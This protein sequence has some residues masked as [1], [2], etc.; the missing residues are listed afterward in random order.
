MR[1]LRLR[2]VEAT[3]KDRGVRVEVAES[4]VEG[5]LDCADPAALIPAE[6]VPGPVLLV[7]AGADTVWPSA[8]MAW[9]LSARLHRNDYPHGHVLLEYAGTGHALGYL[10]P[11]LP[12]GLLPPGVPDDAATRKARRDAWPQV[13]DFLRQ[14]SS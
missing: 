10:I 3:A 4:F 2:F 6:Q 9:A 14:G 8:A 1:R 13:V 7:S 5:D 12:G 11:D